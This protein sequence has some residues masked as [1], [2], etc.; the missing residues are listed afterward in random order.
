MSKNPM[1]LRFLNKETSV[2]ELLMSFS[3]SGDNK[4]A[5][6]AQKT[7]ENPPDIEDFR[8]ELQ[9]AIDDLVKEGVN[10]EFK[11]FVNHYMEVSLEEDRNTEKTP[12]GKNV[13]FSAR[14]KDENE[15]WIQGFIC[16]NL[17]LYIRAF[18]LEELKKCKVCGKIF[19]HKGKWA[20]YCSD[21]C[22]SKK[23]Q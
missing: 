20:V 12:L 9:E 22:K 6:V 1:F 13:S 3:K 10:E 7:L 5:T 17:C 8:K 15:P 23:N 2:T 18:G 16:Y 14:V 19:A 11:A 4:T 21:V